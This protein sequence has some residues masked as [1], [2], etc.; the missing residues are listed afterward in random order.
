MFQTKY[1]ILLLL[2]FAVASCG[3]KPLYKRE[4]NQ[5]GGCKNFSVD[6][7]PLD[8]SGQKLKYNLMDQLNIACIRPEDNFDIT[9]TTLKS[10]QNLGVQKNREVTRYNVILESS[11]SVYDN[12]AKKTIYTSKSR[13]SGA[14]D[15]QISDYGTYAIEQDTYNKLSEDLAREI[16]LKVASKIVDHE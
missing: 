12:S 5:V 16:S 10:K 6:V 13:V 7:K 14:F 11:Y 4:K 2:S 9:V 1:L 15:A 3:F 8:V